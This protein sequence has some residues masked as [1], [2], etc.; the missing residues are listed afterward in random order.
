MKNEISSASSQVGQDIDVAKPD[1]TISNI[2]IQ[3]ILK[4]QGVGHDN[5]I[6]KKADSNK[7]K[8]IKEKLNPVDQQAT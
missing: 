5:Q 3:P 1:T 2:S 4:E 7:L 8:M 6:K